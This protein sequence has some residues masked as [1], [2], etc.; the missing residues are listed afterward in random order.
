MT[1]EHEKTALLQSIV[2]DKDDKDDNNKTTTKKKNKPIAVKKDTKV[3]ADH[4]KSY[5]KGEGN[6][7]NSKEVSKVRTK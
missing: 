3:D 6:K 5:S 7:Q 1:K 4:N 2:H